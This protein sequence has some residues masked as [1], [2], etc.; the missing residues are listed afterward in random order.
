ML[1]QLT[2]NAR[3]RPSDRSALPGELFLLLRSIF[4][5]SA[6]S[7]LRGPSHIRQ[8]SALSRRAFA[9]HIPGEREVYS[10]S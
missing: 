8:R 6:N 1:A 9:F 3:A 5:V 4:W 10:R 2:R 7:G